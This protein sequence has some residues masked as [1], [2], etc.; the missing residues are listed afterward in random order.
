MYKDE[1]V[2]LIYYFSYENVFM[3]NFWWF[4][5]VN[6]HIQPQNDMIWNYNNFLEALL[7]LFTLLPNQTRYFKNVLELFQAWIIQ[8]FPTFS[9]VIFLKKD[10]TYK[11]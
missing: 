8:S 11:S 9:L 7:E 1:F 4:F 10:I 2:E 5:F 6:L 3:D